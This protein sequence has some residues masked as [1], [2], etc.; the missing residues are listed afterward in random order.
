MLSENH[1]RPETVA[2]LHPLHLGQLVG[3]GLLTLR[4]Q[5]TQRGLSCPA[6]SVYR[7]GFSP[8]LGPWPL[9]IQVNK[10]TL[11]TTDLPESQNPSRKE[12]ATAAESLHYLLISGCGERSSLVLEEVVHSHPESAV[13][14][15]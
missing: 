6:M 5:T 2:Q 14:S 9:D 8:P 1:P 3:H 11:A 10:G 7:M 4:T 13:R 15:R 12:W